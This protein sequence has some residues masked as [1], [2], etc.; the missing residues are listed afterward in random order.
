MNQNQQG[1]K[2]QNNRKKSTNLNKV[3]STTDRLTSPDELSQ[4]DD[5]T[6]I[7]I[8]VDA[9]GTGSIGESQGLIIQGLDHLIRNNENAVLDKVAVNKPIQVFFKDKQSMKQQR[10]S[11]LFTTD[12]EKQ[13]KLLKQSMIEAQNFSFSQDITQKVNLEQIQKKSPI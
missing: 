5:A 10:S 13:K 6:G 1:L 9:S 2:P 3:K 4:Q 8:K 7:Y 11:L 12:Q